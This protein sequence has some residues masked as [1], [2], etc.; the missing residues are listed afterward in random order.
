MKPARP[1][2]SRA[3]LFESGAA[4]PVDSI[5]EDADGRW[6]LAYSGGVADDWRD[7]A[8]LDITLRV[9]YEDGRDTRAFVPGRPRRVDQ[10]ADPHPRAARPRRPPRLGRPAPARP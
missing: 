8:D 3:D 9:D 5:T 1:A 7:A 10:L 4:H 2:R 6:H